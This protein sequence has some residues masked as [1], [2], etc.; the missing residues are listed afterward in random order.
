MAKP[1]HTKKGVID[2][3]ALLAKRTQI[4]N[5]TVNNALNKLAEAKQ[6]EQEE[7]VIRH[8]GVIQS[9]TSSAV[10][11]LRGYRTKERAAKAYLVAV[12]EAEQNFYTNADFDAYTE[13]TR[14]AMNE[15]NK[16]PKMETGW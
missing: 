5:A 1:N 12:A 6:K 3:E 13:S 8:L 4:S 11:L 16:V 2:V 9:N 14:V 10:E 15:F 7:Q